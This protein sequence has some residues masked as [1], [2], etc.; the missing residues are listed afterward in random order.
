MKYILRSVVSRSNDMIVGLELGG[1]FTAEKCP[2]GTGSGN[3]SIS[4]SSS[5][6]TPVNQYYIYG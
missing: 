1:S 4:A 2:L 6:P 5:W 3:F